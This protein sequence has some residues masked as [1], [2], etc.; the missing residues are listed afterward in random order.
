MKHKQ[1]SVFAN[2]DV[3]YKVIKATAAISQFFEALFIRHLSQ[4][5]K[6]LRVKQLRYLGC[7]FLYL[8]HAV[9]MYAKRLNTCIPLNDD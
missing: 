3:L 4:S 6:F 7:S 2:Q 8:P 1:T 9:G 5:I